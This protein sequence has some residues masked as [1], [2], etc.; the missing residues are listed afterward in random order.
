MTVEDIC[1]INIV[2]SVKRV[3]RKAGHGGSTHRL[4][5]NYLENDMFNFIKIWFDSWIEEKEKNR[6]KYL[7]GKGK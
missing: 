6:I 5:H 1:G 4:H 7:S 2:Q 3:K